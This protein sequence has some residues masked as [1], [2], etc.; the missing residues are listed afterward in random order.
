M[1][2]FLLV[3][4]PTSSVIPRP[5]PIAEY[6][7]YVPLAGLAVLGIIYGAYCAWVQRDVKKLIAEGKGP[8]RIRDMP[9]R[10]EGDPKALLE[11]VPQQ[12]GMR[13]AVIDTKK[14]RIAASLRT[15]RLP[16]AIALSPDARR[17]AAG[18]RLARVRRAKRCSQRKRAGALV[19]SHV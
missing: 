4:A 8:R 16:F 18:G 11:A 10:V 15:G 6:R 1:I 13:L 2:W 12:E 3:L 14:K 19:P 9:P 17:L 7:M 5:D